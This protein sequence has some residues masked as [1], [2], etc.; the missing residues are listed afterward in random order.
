MSLIVGVR[1]RKIIDPRG[2]SAVEAEVSLASGASGRAAVPFCRVEATELRDGS[3]SRRYDKSALRAVTN[4]ETIIAPMLIGMDALDQ[5]AIDRTMLDLDATD[6]KANLGADSILSVSL[7]AAR[8]AAD[9]LKIP[10]YRY[11][12]GVNA[13]QMPTPMMTLLHGGGYAGN[14]LDFR[15]FMIVPGGAASWSEA[16]RMG[17]E[18]FHNLRAVLKSRGYDTAVSADGGFASS[19]RSN[20]EALVCL[21]QAIRRAGYRPGP[22]VAI[23]INAAAGRF[24]DAEAAIY[25]LS[26]EGRLLTGTKLIDYYEDML[27]RYPVIS[28]ED[29]LA[30][31]DWEGWQELTDR[32]G[33]IVQLVGGDLFATN[34]QRLRQGIRMRAANAILIKLEQAGSITEM[35]DCIETARRAGWAAVASHLGGDPDDEAMADIAVGVNSWQIKISAPSVIG[36][37]N[38]YNRLLS[39]EDELNSAAHFDGWEAFGDFSA[40]DTIY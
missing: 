1:A 24:Y 15:E 4:V 14:N 20:D 40:D 5:A 12:G 13:K 38:K 9:Y 7:A 31:D 25:Q 34:P 22:D 16:L 26:G 27:R 36:N 3:M 2:K 10:L 28:I 19:L 17:A 11:I 18:V 37:E 6:N 39:I 33:P 30:G 32:L 29:G 21:V 23:A 35:L 8:A